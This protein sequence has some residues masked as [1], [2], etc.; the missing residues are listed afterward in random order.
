MAI[1]PKDARAM[2]IPSGVEVSEGVSISE[3]RPAPGMA[4]D[5]SGN[6]RVIT[7]FIVRDISGPS[8]KSIMKELKGSSGPWPKRIGDTGAEYVIKELQGAKKFNNTAS[9]DALSDILADVNNYIFNLVAAERDEKGNPL[10]VP[11][12]DKVQQDQT[13]A[14][15]IGLNKLIKNGFI[16]ERSALT[17]LR[18]GLSSEKPPEQGPR[19]GRLVNQAQPD[20]I[21]FSEEITEEVQ[22]T[23]EQYGMV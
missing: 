3:Q 5:T 2:N 16:D 12:Q 19:L 11:P 8:K 1:V 22:P 15:S 10:Y 4:P 21:N 23:G 9:P 20:Q 13:V 6:V 17:W 18:E 14:L 7:D